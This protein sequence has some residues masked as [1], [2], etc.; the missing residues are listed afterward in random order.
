MIGDGL[1]LMV[2]GL[3]VVF[4]F[5]ILLYGSV[6]LLGKVLDLLPQPVSVVPV[7]KSSP[8][9]VQAGELVAVISAAISTHRRSRG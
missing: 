8:A 7:K 3:S 6:V 5:L 9:A 1:I 4:A 2:L